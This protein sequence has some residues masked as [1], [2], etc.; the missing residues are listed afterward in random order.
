MTEETWL[1]DPEED[2]CLFV[3]GVRV[4]LDPDPGLEHAV[5][6]DA[7]VRDHALGQEVEALKAE[8]DEWEQ[9]ARRLGKPDREMV[10]RLEQENAALRAALK[11]GCQGCAVD[12]PFDTETMH[13]V[14]TDN[15]KANPLGWYYETCRLKPSQRA[16]LAASSGA[17]PNA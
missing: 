11:S 17:Q 3:G 2:C 13:R 12:A 10:E 7:I 9:L 14:P 5:I 15:L 16:A 4:H 6:R 8:R 1:P